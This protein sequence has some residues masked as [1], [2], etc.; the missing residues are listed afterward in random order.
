MGEKNIYKLSFQGVVYPAVHCLIS[1]WAPPAEKGKFISATLG[2][3]LGTVLTWPFLGILLI[4]NINNNNINLKL[5]FLGTV[6]EHLDWKWAFYISGIVVL[7][8]TVLWV[9]LVYDSPDQHPWIDDK[10]RDYIVASLSGTV[11][12][13][14]VR[15]CLF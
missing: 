11:S 5:N 9:L 10:E 14:A 13:K 2:G 8:W 4:K 12:T 3:S 6:M 15:E 7:L 1:K